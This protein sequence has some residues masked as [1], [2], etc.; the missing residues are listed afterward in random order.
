MCLSEWVNVQRIVTG[1]WP[2]T[3]LLLLVLSCSG[4]NFLTVLFI[5]NEDYYFLSE[6]FFLLQEV[7]SS[8]LQVP[9]KNILRVLTFENFAS[10]M[11]GNQFLGDRGFPILEDAYIDIPFQY[12]ERLLC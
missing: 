5:T 11:P 8:K 4:F 6:C 9:L 10:L 3:T 12:P 2:H 1:H 7:I